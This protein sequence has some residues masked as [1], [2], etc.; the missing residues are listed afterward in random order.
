MV[1]RLHPDQMIK[2]LAKA[3]FRNEARTVSLKIL[4][5]LSGMENP[6][7]ALSRVRPLFEDADW[8]RRGSRLAYLFGLKDWERVAA[9]WDAKGISGWMRMKSV[10]I[11]QKLSERVRSALT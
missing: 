3:R 10:Q 7:E 9:A 4:D 2:H 1:Y 6:V 5:V 11:R 8:H